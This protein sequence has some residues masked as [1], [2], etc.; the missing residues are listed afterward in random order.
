MKFSKFRTK[1]IKEFFKKLPGILGEH[2]FLTF[3]GLLLIALILSGFIFYKYSFLVKKE[4]PEIFGK[5]LQF[6][7]EDCQKVLE[8]WQNKAKISEEIDLKQYPDPFKID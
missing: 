5:L 6:K 1:K 2:S 8:I 7:E 3:L 4:E